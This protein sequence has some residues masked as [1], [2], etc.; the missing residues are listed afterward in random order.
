MRWT[1]ILVAAG[2]AIA[3]LL[4]GGAAT[5]IGP[6]YFSLHKPSWQP[7]DWLFAPVWTVIYALTALSGVIAWRHTP[8]RRARQRL[9]LLFAVNAILNVLWSDLFFAMRRPDWALI[10]VVPFWLSILALFLA[11]RRASRTASNLLLPYLLWVLFAGWLN[12][13]IV[14]LNGPFGA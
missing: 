13:A 5:D 4:L 12:L 8:D 9:L 7:P 14:R 2:A 3:V 10:E 6:W 1:P 11:T